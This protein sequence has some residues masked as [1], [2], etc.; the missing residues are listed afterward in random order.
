[1]KKITKKMALPLIVAATMLAGV[2]AWAQVSNGIAS[3]TS[4]QAGQLI[5]A[6]G[7]NVDFRITLHGSFEQHALVTS[8]T[9]QPEIR[10]IVNGSVAWAS[11]V[12]MSPFTASNGG[13]RTEALFRYTVKPGDMAQPLELF[14]N[15]GIGQSPGD[16]FKFN[17]NGWQISRVG[18]TSTIAVWVFDDTSFVS[19]DI[20]DFN[21][22]KANVKLRTLKFEDATSPITVA[23][24]ES[25]NWHVTTVNPIESAVVDFYV[26]PADYS[27]IQVGANTNQPLLVSMPTGSTDVDF[28]VRGQAVGETDI[29]LQRTV[30][31]DNNANPLIGVTNYIR[32]A[33]EVTAPPAPT[34]RVVMI[35]N[36]G[37]NITMDETGSLSTGNFNVELSE[38]YASDV[39][40][41][42]DTAIAGLVQT[43]VTFAN[44][45][46]FVT[47]SA[48]DTVSSDQKFNVP[49]GTQL[50]TATGVTLTPTITNAMAAANYSRIR[51]A[52][53]YVNNAN[54]VII[55]P[56][57]TDVETVIRGVNTAFDFF[58]QDVP[59]DNPSMITRWTFGDSTPSM[60]VTGH[61]GNAFHTY[62]AIGTY[63]VKMEAQDK[64][65]DPSS[66][67]ETIFTVNVEPPQPSPSVSLVTDSFVYD[68]TGDTATG[69][70]KVY[71][72]EASTY[73]V[74]VRIETDPAG[75]SNIALSTTNAFRIAAGTTNYANTVRFSLVD[76]TDDSA[77]TGITLRPVVTNAVA[78]AHYTDLKETAIYVNNV[79]PVITRPVAATNLSLP[80]SS[81][82][83]YDQVPM[84]DPFTFTYNVDDVDADLSSM[85][86]HWEFGDGGTLDAVGA[87]GTVSHTY[88]SLGDRIVSVRAT[89][90]DGGNSTWVEFKVTVVTPPPD[91]TVSII[92]PN[93][94][95]YENQDPLS[96]FITVQL[97]EAFTNNVVVNLSMDIADKIQLSV[98]QVIFNVGQ[99]TK[100]VYITAL[101]GTSA[102]LAPGVEIT[103]DVIA[104]PAAINHFLIEESGF[105]R[106][107]N[108]IPEIVNPV[109]PDDG[110]V[111]Y[112]VPQGG[113]RAY[114][115]DI[116]DV[117]ADLTGMIVTWRWGD[118]SPA[119][120]VIG[121]SGAITHSYSMLGEALIQVSAQDKDGGS[122]QIA[123]SVL[124]QPAKAVNVTPIG[125]NKE[126]SYYGAA[127]L[128]DGTV[129]STEARGSDNRNNVYFFKYDPN[130]TSAN[131]VA[132][133]YKAGLAG[134]T[135]V[136]YDSLGNSFSDP[137]GVKVLDSFFYVWG[138]VDQGLPEAKLVPSTTTPTTSITLP[139]VET[140]DAGDTASVEIRD[141]QAI[142]SYERYEEDNM[143]DINQDGIPDKISQRYG[144]G[145]AAAA[146]AENPGG[147]P[148]DLINAAGYN[149]DEDYIPLASS[150]NSA[151]TSNIFA[152]LGTEFTAWL[153]VRGF[154]E[155]LNNATYGSDP[156]G[157]L[158][159][160]GA[161][162]IVGGT[163]PLDPDTDGDTFPD[164]WEYYFWYNAEIMGMTGES[165]SPSDVS[166]GNLIRSRDIADYFD[167]L[168]PAVADATGSAYNRDTDND[169]LSDVEELTIG[170]NPVHWDTDGDGMCDGW[171]VLRGLNP[172]DSTDAASNPDGDYMAY[173]SVP[174]EWVTVAGGGI[175]NNYL[176][177]DASIGTTNGTFTTWYNYGDTNSLIA[178]GHPVVLAANQLVIASADIEA[179]IM[180]FQVR[181]EFGFDPR[182]AWTDTIDPTR[183]NDTTVEGDA[184][185]TRPFTSLNEYLLMKF[186]SENQVNGIGTSIAG[187]SAAWVA[188]S[189]HPLTPDTDASSV[190]VDSMPDGWELYV[191]TQPDMRDF[192]ISPWN[193]L[194]NDDDRDP[195]DDRNPDDGEGL[196]V[197]R[198]YSGIYSSGQYTN[199][200]LYSSGFNTVSIRLQDTYWVN[201]FW[202]TDPWEKDTDADGVEDAE[203]M[204]F[205]YGSPVDGGGLFTAGG[206]L[207]PCSVDT[208]RDA[209]PDAWEL[210]FLGTPVTDNGSMVITNGMNGTVVDSSRDWDSDGLRNYQEY[211]VQ[212][213]RSFRYDIPSPDVVDADGV[214]LITKNSPLPMDTSFAVS[215]LFVKVDAAWDIA[216]KPWWPKDTSLWVMLKVNEEAYVSTDPRDEDT[217]TDEM[218]DYYEMFHGLNP[219]LGFALRDDRTDDRV[220]MAYKDEEEREIHAWG[221]NDFGLMLPKNFMA[222]PWLTGMPNSDV[223]ADG[224]LNFE[225]MILPNAASPAYYNTD[226][227]PLWLTDSGNPDSIPARSYYNGGMFFWPGDPLPDP[228]DQ[229]FSYEM[230]EGYDTDNDG[231]NDKAELVPGPNGNSDPQDHDD[232]IRRQALWFDGVQSAA[233]TPAAFAYSDWAFRSFTVELWAMPEV[234][235][236]NQVL[237]ERRMYYAASDLSITNGVRRNFRIGIKDDGRVYAMFQNAGG[238]DEQSG[239]VI[240]YGRVLNVD[241]WVHLAACMDGA[242][243][244]FRLLVNG[245][246]DAVVNTD[247]IPANGV[248]TLNMD[249]QNPGDALSVVVSAGALVLGAANDSIGGDL[250]DSWSAYNPDSFYKGY[251]DEVR[252][253]D[254]ARS[255]GAINADLRK[256]Y[257]Y[258]ELTENRRDVQW[259]QSQGYSRVASN[260]LL[261]QPELR[262][263]YTFDNLFSSY[264]P[265]TV[266][267]VPRGFMSDAV[268]TNRPVGTV[269]S[270]WDGMTATRSF[271]YTNSAYIPWIE[272]GV[273]HLPLTSRITGSET[274]AS[275]IEFTSVQD[276]VYWSR[277]A[278]GS[279]AVINDFKINN[280]PYG[281]VY[282]AGGSI[283]V[284]Q[285]ILP[286]GGAYAKT[287]TTMWDE[288]GVSS[289]WPDSNLDSDYDGM[290]DWWEIANGLDPNSGADDDGWYG[291]VDPGNRGWTNG[292][293][294]LRDLARGLREGDAYDSPSGPAQTADSDYDGMPDWW[295]GIYSLDKN[296]SVGDH[297]ANG[298][299]D[300]DGLPNLSEY[301]ISE[302]YQFRYISPRLF[303][304]T[305]DQPFS[306]Y[307]L[308]QGQ[309]TLGAMFTDHDFIEDSWEDLYD[310]YYISSYVYDPH[311]DNDE[312]GWSNWAEAC[313][314]SMS[315]TVKPD[316]IVS[317]LPEMETVAE[318]PIPVIETTLRYDGFQTVGDLV[319]NSYSTS[320]M[321]GIPD[322]SYTF[323]YN[324]DGTFQETK[325]YYLGVWQP[326]VYTVTLS[327][328]SIAPGTIVLTF[329]DQ[330]NGES[331]ATG[332]DIDGIICRR[333]LNGDD[334]PFG[335]IN[336]ETGE[337]VLDLSIYDNGN[338]IPLSSWDD[339]L[340][341]S[342]QDRDSYL[343]IANS[344]VG[345]NYSVSLNNTWPKKLYLGKSDTGRIREGDN[346]FFA[347]LDLDSSGTWNAGEP[348]GLPEQFKTDIGWDRNEMII[349]LTD[350]RPGYLRFDLTTGLRS[351]DV[352]LGIDKTP[353]LPSTATFKNRVRVIRTVGFMTRLVL[354]RVITQGRTYIHEGDMLAQ[355]DLALGWDI[356]PDAWNNVEG[357]SYDVYMG[358]IDRTIDN[359]LVTSFTNRFDE[360][361][362]RAESTKPIHGG[363]VYSSRPVFRWNMPDN[364]P[365]FSIEIRKNSPMGT[366]VYESG[367][368][369][370]P[371]RDVET[372]EYIWEAPI[373]A[374][375]TL[376]Q[377]GNNPV[378]TF[379]VNTVYAWRVRA[380]D[381]KFTEVMDDDVDWSEWKM[382]RL[383]VNS[384]MESSGYGMIDA[385]VKYFGPV[386]NLTNLVKVQA[387]T[388]AD[389]S[390]IAD[391]MYTLTPAELGSLTDTSSTNINAVLRGL[392]P[393]EFAGTYYVM[394]YIDS[395]TN[396][397]RDV[398]ESWGYAN[399]Y[400][401]SSSLGPYVA[402]P[403]TVKMNTYLPH[404]SIFIEDADT[405]QDWFPDAWE[406]ESEINPDED[407]LESIGP[408]GTWSGSEDIGYTE[409]NADL[410]YLTNPWAGTIALLAFG[411]TDSDG[412][413]VDDFKEMILGTDAAV[414]NPGVADNLLLGLTP[415]DTLELNVA[416]LALVDEF[417][418]MTWNL[419][420]DKAESNLSQGMLDLMS[421]DADGTVTYTIEVTP[422]L[423]NP[424]WTTVQSGNV[425]L[426]G[427]QALINQI[428]VD[429]SAVSGFYRV[430]LGN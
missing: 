214:G 381:A 140:T 207:N 215:N 345:I 95:I 321:D 305:V 337:I 42:I 139:E 368:V 163:D 331:S 372:G 106:V 375:N 120:V 255:I 176:A 51:K 353:N 171:E 393:S 93:S 6:S 137:A 195:G 1:M 145:A 249:Q 297:G 349:E 154:D 177:V 148:A 347:F 94:P 43:N 311:E 179:L 298:D 242:S 98:S 355:G 27:V 47:I 248:E 362:A 315:R 344:S 276:S 67:I 174:R 50:S 102:T 241:E 312:D 159:E 155:G 309:M 303:K 144:L 423:S 300:R 166:Q 390:G 3:I 289:T 134:Y 112:S 428:S 243:G 403:V 196:I 129:T 206:G 192:E 279:Y 151:V 313:Y 246:I 409:V 356:T 115:W 234:I 38:A 286:L 59:A 222:Y 220:A 135:A 217:D 376:P 55:R 157:P 200:A 91:P 11:L 369:K 358:D 205:M 221:Y 293:R 136:H 164:G 25:V 76:G 237:I 224:L 146:I 101:D 402:E 258:T 86:V 247:L 352:V 250:P 20:F 56:E 416:G 364:Y 262:Y 152:T 188:A 359:L 365:A 45:P 318:Y 378:Q 230:N 72:S 48:G 383:D 350:Y 26:W 49:D 231:V 218:D 302:L 165:Y 149:G 371:S 44:N 13:L 427:S 199:S 81:A 203:E 295:E 60:V 133:P 275:S 150:G 334:D 39:V 256:R 141:V 404:V 65:M 259:E 10:M 301:L 261:L 273:Y 84:G 92:V 156:S 319:I 169:G 36:G 12:S 209:L 142:F 397:V 198:E 53:V 216:R 405:D 284:K 299:Y 287:V 408:S 379:S 229:L 5:T 266:A 394:A 342:E 89:D 130:I 292:E 96:D 332:Y 265:E 83:G 271:V 320:D 260:N 30:D 411:S 32:R 317:L 370:A 194:D 228:G 63:Q 33:I 419:D 392:T 235:D 400:G 103:P 80:A 377:I 380:M 85:I 128:G 178:V 61:Q 327:P 395:N 422:S 8:P 399:Y 367:A 348:C 197:M 373:H 88:V 173:A 17:W 161:D 412:D 211:W 121:G 23:A 285:D 117:D 87:N 251:I 167:P 168:V 118:G 75:Q 308:R 147:L 339:A 426:E 34:V 296:S 160:P 245:E 351:E 398:W 31:Y 131:L 77:L 323:A 269:A 104:T 187:D 268:T 420:V 272:N 127:G 212:A 239:V 52:T 14:G 204:A 357:A 123:F 277:Y 264:S 225:E 391:S 306:D 316:A 401:K 66:Y 341:F 189:T 363:Y 181:D 138:G 354:D 143:G 172:N 233:Q 125:P 240:A 254:G 335:T 99:T 282:N 208:D 114:N 236:R 19:G 184:P 16:S 180:H 328:G 170:T 219:I 40:I 132:I 304:T 407:F 382:F 100:D 294:Y 122:M 338:Y 97:S 186:M 406:W 283:T 387:F 290:A 430:K 388:S 37:D 74:W 333:A 113:S 415:D 257:T 124:I 274:G 201:K 110:E 193:R 253:W 119:E 73:P 278:A 270:W 424:S 263:H 343:L 421:A 213:V 325:E 126:A 183:F 336:Y 374:G 429:A 307:F 24:T 360:F 366:L 182:T 21:L 109:V 35:D 267:L 82:Y 425:T 54:P 361:H 22:T 2:N 190:G 384:P 28:V 79:A 389:F 386:N 111:A 15:S 314:A 9:L 223:D 288:Q 385:S 227:T 4:D 105:V 232:P 46:F 18:D 417:I 68:E 29:Y 244:E 413:G 175:T 158:D 310:P 57:S 322:A 340:S 7:V 324:A 162:G 69:Q 329:V 414:V 71:L 41:R 108:V 58:V 226:P 202:P 107:R 64:D 62:T 238:H 252:V 346:Y 185:N 280:D 291:L 281:Y 78:A 210:Q 326:K 410:V 330:R 153:E 70:I 396:N 191:A 116:D 418:Q 90:K